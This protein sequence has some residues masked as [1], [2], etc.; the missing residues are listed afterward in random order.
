MHKLKVYIEKN[1]KSRH[2]RRRCLARPGE[3]FYKSMEFHVICVLKT[4]KSSFDKKLPSYTFNIYFKYSPLMHK[5]KVYIEKN[6][7]MIFWKF[8]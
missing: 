7:K 1:K 8:F 4:E 6:K 3:T 2:N 5:L